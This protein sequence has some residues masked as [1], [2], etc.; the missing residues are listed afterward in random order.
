[1]NTVAEQYKALQHKLL[2]Q[3]SE[4][5][6]LEFEK[7]KIEEEFKKAKQ[8]HEAT[9]EEKGKLLAKATEEIQALGEKSKLSRR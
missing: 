6:K 4:Q 5:Q 8:E 3:E 7:E 1:M 9:M 2:T